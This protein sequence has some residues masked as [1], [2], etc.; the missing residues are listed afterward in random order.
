MRLYLLLLALIPV[1]LLS[2]CIV[3]NN[4]ETEN[5]KQI[6][7]KACG[8][9]VKTGRDLSNGPCLLNPIQEYPNWVCDVAHEPRQTVDDSP[10]NQCSAFRENEAPHFAEVTPDCN[11]IRSY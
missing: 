3:K 7:I 5:A 1:I 2:G 11:F 10:E 8:D 6:C 4:S 9:A